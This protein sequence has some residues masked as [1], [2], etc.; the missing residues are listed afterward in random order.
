[1]RVLRLSGAVPEK[2]AGMEAYGEDFSAAFSARWDHWG[3]QSWSLIAPHLPAPVPDRSWLDL[4]CGSGGLMGIAAANGY[5]VVGVD[6]SAAQLAHARAKVPA[7]TLIE[8]DI[9]ALALP[10]RFDVVT[11][12]FDSL[13]YLLRPGD[14]EKA[15]RVGKQ[16]LK[17]G[18]LFAFDLKTAE[19]FRSE[20]PRVFKH[21][22]RVVVFET[23][24]DEAEG[25]HRFDVTGFV[26]ES[27]S[28]RR[29]AEQH[30]Q[31]AYDAESVDVLLRR[32]K[33]DF[34]CLDLETGRKA[35]A[36]SRRLL[37]LCRR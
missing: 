7:A 25:L 1:M 9:T 3:R 35:K 2:G 37:Y 33:L 22:D 15:L 10:D 31:R 5:A 28:Y 29:F 27:G 21:P 32:L 4:C 17:A 6:R 18:G 30:V 13:N 20:R 14:L 11:C 23:S 36:R 12:M 16:H 8:A 24:F 19:G 26:A 34:Q